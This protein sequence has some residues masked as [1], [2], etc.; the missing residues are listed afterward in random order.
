MSD[1][2]LGCFQVYADLN[3]VKYRIL[4]VNA[5]PVIGRNS[6]CS[7]ENEFDNNNKSKQIFR[8]LAFKLGGEGGGGGGGGVGGR[9]Q[10]PDNIH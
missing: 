6:H 2:L 5:N 1:R 10:K 9:K 3:R 4:P 7:N 8:E